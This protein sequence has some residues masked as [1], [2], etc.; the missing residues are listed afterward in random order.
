MLIAGDKGADPELYAL[1]TI[2]QLATVKKRLETVRSRAKSHRPDV[3][4]IFSE[5][6]TDGAVLQSMQEVVH[7]AGQQRAK[8]KE[9]KVRVFFH[10][11]TGMAAVLGR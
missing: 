5:H 1:L 7:M 6:Q 10:L 9:T 11:V 8:Q 2:N 4:N 3:R